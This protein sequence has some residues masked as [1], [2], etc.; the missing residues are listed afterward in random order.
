MP[1]AALMR[2]FWAR[3]IVAETPLASSIAAAVQW[4]TIYKQRNNKLPR[5]PVPDHRLLFDAVA[6]G[7]APAA[8]AAMRHLIELALADIGPLEDAADE[9]AGG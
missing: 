2:A 3:V 1:V 9:A 6:N 4:T 8:H 5:D 7:D